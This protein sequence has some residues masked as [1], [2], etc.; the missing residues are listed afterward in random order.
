MQKR[1]GHIHTPFCPHGTSDPFRAYIE[2]AEKSGF[3]DISFTEHAPLPEG[4]TDTTPDQDSGMGLAELPA[5]FNALEEAKA[6]FPGMRIRSGLEVDYIQGLE[7]Q[8]AELLGQAGTELEDAILSVHFLRCLDRYICFDFSAG[9]FMDLAK[10][11]GSVQAV[12]DLYYDTVEA[13][14]LADLGPH[15]PKRIGHPTLCHKFQHIHREHIDDDARIRKI[16]RMI[17]EHGY[18]LDVNSAGLS[19]PGCLE[20][21]PPEPYIAYAREL[22]IP[23]VFGSDA[24]SAEGLH[25][26][27]ERFYT[28]HY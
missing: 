25:K 9:A 13:S 26:F 12:Y 22:G 14:I 6:Q 10:D 18:E 4:F 17:K 8:T 23:L 24:H 19:K 1:D 20:F 15:K 2:K 11:M 3:T 27:A 21:Y 28:E 7:K 16:L 5:Y